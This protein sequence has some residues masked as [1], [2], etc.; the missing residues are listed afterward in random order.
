MHLFFMK[1]ILDQKH[2]F[3]F[4]PSHFFLDL[5]QCHFSPKNKTLQKVK[6]SWQIARKKRT[7]GWKERNQM[8]YHI[9]NFIVGPRGILFG[10]FAFPAS[11]W[12]VASFEEVRS[13]KVNKDVT[14][15]AME[16][17]VAPVLSAIAADLRKAVEKFSATILMFALES[18]FSFARPK[19]KA[20]K[21]KMKTQE[22]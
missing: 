17:T 21:L 9:K 11:T 4:K 15:N 19:V 16:S 3:H 7:I 10:E 13:L 14:R 5:E 2:V 12:L 22:E 8:F 18:L 6:Y 1:K 20:K